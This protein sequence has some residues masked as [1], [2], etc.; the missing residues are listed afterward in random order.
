[1]VCSYDDPAFAMGNPDMRRYRLRALMALLAVVLPVELGPRAPIT[2]GLVRAALAQDVAV[3]L[4]ETLGEYGRWIDHPRWGAVWVPGGVAPDWRPYRLGRWIYTD[5]W[6]W[7]WVADEAWGWIAY[8]YGRWT[9]DRGLGWIW[10]PG[11]DWGPAWVTWR[12]GED[13]V[14]WA[15]M[16]PDDIAVAEEGDWDIWL[17]VRTPDLIA[18]NVAVQVLPLQRTG[19]FMRRTTIV[20]RT[21]VVRENGR[22]T[23]ADPGVPPAFVAA[24]VG[25]PIQSF[26]VL[27]HV[28]RGTVG[29]TGAV[30]GAPPRGAAAHEEINPLAT[31]IEPAAG[32][33]PQAPFKPGPSPILGPNP[34]HALRHTHLT[35]P[36]L[37]LSNMPVRGTHRGPRASVPATGTAPSGLGNWLP[38]NPFRAKPPAEAATTP[39][40]GEIHVP[41]K[42]VPPKPP[43]ATIAQPAGEFH[44]PAPPN[45]HPPKPPAVT[46]TNPPPP[47]KC[48]V[49]DG[50]RVCN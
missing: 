48:T 4:P 33:Q 38:S 11:S 43:S 18:S 3:E 32:V 26:A 1:M 5:E 30:V 44:V 8:H 13:A 17:F 2:N 25:R 47:K 42:P 31:L 27:P 45:S 10:L 6:G 9:L 20:N 50:E 40:A 12:R 39:A 15:P 41:S 14:G 16:P 21:V 37:P 36:G 35:R 49:V 46:P 7:Y 28:L 29:V 19:A 22:V 34:L 23:V 24:Q